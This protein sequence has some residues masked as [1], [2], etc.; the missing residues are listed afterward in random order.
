MRQA[1]FCCC[2]RHTCTHHA[3]NGKR[4]FTS[5]P[6][7][8]AAVT[9]ENSEPQRQQKS[10][11]I[12]AWPHWEALAGVTTREYRNGERVSSSFP[13]PRSWRLQNSPAPGEEQRTG[14]GATS[15]GCALPD[16][17]ESSYLSGGG[18]CVCVLRAVTVTR[19]RYQSSLY[20]GVR[21]NGG[22]CS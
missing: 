22:F 12:L 1:H 5:D 11:H 18:E 13:G 6:L 20:S 19:E 4:C 15:L 7:G 17:L 3:S 9:A 8:K 21:P 16:L 10:A 14:P 2:S